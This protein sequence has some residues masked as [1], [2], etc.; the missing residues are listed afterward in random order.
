MECK[1]ARVNEVRIHGICGECLER[2]R[3]GELEDVD[4]QIHDTSVPRGQVQTKGKVELVLLKYW[5]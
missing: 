3:G 5:K 2:S 1:V 4:G